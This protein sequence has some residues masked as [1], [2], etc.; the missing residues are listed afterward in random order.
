MSVCLFVF[1]K[2]GLSVRLWSVLP[3]SVY[4]GAAKDILTKR[5]SIIIVY[6]CESVRDGLSLRGHRLTHKKGGQENIVGEG[7]VWQGCHAKTLMLSERRY[8]S[9]GF[10]F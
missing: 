8:G 6:S 10:G 7:A 9:S 5:Y 2:A 4:Q 3:V 1:I